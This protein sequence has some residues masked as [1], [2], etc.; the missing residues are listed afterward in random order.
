MD[1]LHLRSAGTSLVISFDSG[2]AEVIHWG[3]DLGA[4]LPDLAILGDR[5]PTPP[6]MPPS[7]P[8][9]CR[10]H[11]P[12]GADARPS[13]GTA[14]PT[15]SPA[16]TSPSASAS[17]PSTLAQTAAANSA[18]IV[19]SDPDAGITVESTLQL[20]DGGL[21]EMRH[22]VTNTGTSPFQLDELA[23]VLPVAP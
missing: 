11:P 1:P 2:E 18:V 19:Q 6:S 16:T 22:T 5:S 10:R 3:A 15:A 13:A 12:A 9:C 23:T 8:D 20:H 21:L 7:L 4:S 14:S 17:R